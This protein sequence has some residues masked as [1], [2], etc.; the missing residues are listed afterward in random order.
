MLLGQHCEIGRLGP[1][2][3]ALVGRRAPPWPARLEVLGAFPPVLGAED[4]TTV[5]QAQ[6]NFQR[7]AVTQH[8]LDQA[9][10]TLD[11]AQAR[12]KIGL[13]SIVELSQAQLAQTQAQIDYT[14]A[15]YAYQGSLAAIRYQT[16]Q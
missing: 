11:L 12:Y 16:G 9:N 1:A 7:I 15:R 8:L 3:L 14:N 4:R 13:S 6:S 5:L 2:E 10:L